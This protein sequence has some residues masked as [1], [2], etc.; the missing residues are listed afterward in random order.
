MTELSAKSMQAKHHALLSVQLQSLAKEGQHLTKHLMDAFSAVQRDYLT[1][2]KSLCVREGT[3]PLALFAD[4]EQMLDILKDEQS[5]LDLFCRI[6]EEV[7][8]H[9]SQEE[10]DA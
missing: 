7:R 1:R 4:A 10:G 5:T 6:E 3:I 9:L 2:L 8:E